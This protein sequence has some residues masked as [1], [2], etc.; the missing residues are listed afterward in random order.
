MN[1]TFLRL[2]VNKV[3]HLLT[4]KKGKNY[5][6]LEL[7]RLGSTKNN[8]RYLRV[9]SKNHNTNN[10]K[11]S[12]TW[13][14]LTLTRPNILPENSLLWKD[15]AIQMIFLGISL[16]IILKET[17]T[18]LFLS[19]MAFMQKLDSLSKSNAA[20]SISWL[21]EPAL[22]NAFLD[23]TYLVCPKSKTSVTKKK[24][25]W[26]RDATCLQNFCNSFLNVHICLN[27]KNSMFL[28]FLN[29]TLRH[30]LNTWKMKRH[31][32]QHRPFQDIK[33][34]SWSKETSEK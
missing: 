27:L 19:L 26:K 2:E 31:S 34:I 11:S 30:N 5:L 28:C 6:E 21:S 33:G 12:K 15:T 4:R 10:S 17:E 25:F 1:K 29:K 9:M 7:V 24:N 14:H 22:S 16:F 23:C 20:T 18:I 8:N 3:L 13:T 32:I